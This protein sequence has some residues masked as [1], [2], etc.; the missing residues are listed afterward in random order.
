MEAEHILIDQGKVD[1]AIDMY[2]SLQRWDDA[3]GVAETQGH[4]QASHMKEQYMQVRASLCHA[5]AV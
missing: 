3:I 5:V 2:Q 1:E 4:P